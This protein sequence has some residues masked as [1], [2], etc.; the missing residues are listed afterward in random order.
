MILVGHLRIGLARKD[1]DWFRCGI[2]AG[3]D[4]PQQRAGLIAR[5]GTTSRPLVFALGLMEDHLA[6]TLR[7]ERI[8]ALAG[9]S[10][11]HLN[12]LF[13]DAL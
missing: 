6:D 11:R 10:A 3:K 8:A 12:R 1:A 9:V 2:G 7:L 4:R 5:Y 13:V